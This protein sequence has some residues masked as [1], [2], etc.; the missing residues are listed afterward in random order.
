MARCATAN[1]AGAIPG[2]RPSGSR[3]PTST[4]CWALPATRPVGDR[5]PPRQSTMPG[6]AIADMDAALAEGVDVGQLLEQLLGYF[7]DAMAAAVGCPGRHA[8]AHLAGGS[9]PS[10][11]STAKQLGLETILAIMQILDHTLYTTLRYSTQSR[12]LGEMAV[13]CHISS[14]GGSGSAVGA[15]R[16]NCEWAPHQGPVPSRTGASRAALSEGSRSPVAGAKK[17]AELSQPR[18]IVADGSKPPE[19]SATGP[20]VE[21]TAESTAEVWKQALASLSDLLAESAALRRTPSRW[22]SWPGW[23]LRPGE[24]YFV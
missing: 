3:W 14:L 2:L 15:D 9:Q 1:P 10:W 20:I 6:A 21:L 23:P 13:T 22:A 24:V 16:P 18:D 12:T 8:A 7:R 17:K 19:S 4:R 11:S 5:S